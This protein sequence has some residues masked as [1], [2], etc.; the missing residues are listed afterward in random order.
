MTE[1]ARRITHSPLFQHFITLI[2]LLAGAVVGLETSPTAVARWGDSFRL[3]DRIVL[4]IFVLE[5][6]IKLAAEGK[7][8]WRYFRD[9]W[10]VFDFSIVAV[11]LLPV[12]GQYITVLRLARLLRVLRLVHAL[13]RLQILVSALLR[14][15]PSMGY[16]GMF[17]GLLFYVYGVAAVFLF[18]QNDPVHFANLGRAM[19]SLFTVVTLEGWADL[20]YTQ[21]YGCN[22]FGYDAMQELCRQPLAHP[23]AAPIFFISFVLF[24]TMI[25][26]NLFIGVIMNSMQEAAIEGEKAAEAKRFAKEGRHAASV[27]H[28]L[29][30]LHAALSGLSDRLARIQ[31]R[32]A[33]EAPAGRP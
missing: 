14:S 17:L 33:D 31:K 13:P 4:G 8:P 16:V 9:P 23:I 6:A 5:I 11:S 32:L 2:I 7:T 3:L 26:L 27:E 20:M 22:A 30:E 18:A 1:A 15:I 19:L 25:V 10:N 21:M 24:G 29:F 12:D 28:E